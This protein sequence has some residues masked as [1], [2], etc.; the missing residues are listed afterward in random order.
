MSNLYNQQAFGQPTFTDAHASGSSSGRDTFDVIDSSNLYYDP[1]RTYQTDGQNM[2]Q[3]HVITHD[4]YT[5]SQHLVYALQDSSASVAGKVTPPFIF[6]DN[7]AIQL[8]YSVHFLEFKSHLPHGFGVKAGSSGLSAFDDVWP[9][10]DGVLP[11]VARDRSMQQHMQQRP[12]C[13]GRRLCKLIEDAFCWIDVLA[14][15]IRNAHRTLRISFHNTLL[16]NVFKRPPI[17]FANGAEHE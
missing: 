3:M 8:L 1:D 14:D 9:G 17:H 12:T 7:F 5:Q 16:T 10:A 11:L 6:F 4:E 13:F 15:Q 2:Q